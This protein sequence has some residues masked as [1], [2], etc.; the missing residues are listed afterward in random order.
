MSGRWWWWWCQD[1]D[2]DDDDDDDDEKAEEDDDND[3]EDDFAFAFDPVRR[4]TARLHHRSSNVKKTNVATIYKRY[5][6][7]WRSLKQRKQRRCPRG[8]K[9]RCFRAISNQSPIY[10]SGQ[11][12]VFEFAI[13]KN[14]C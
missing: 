9:D 11:N 14:D 12:F 2:G 5:M 10:A 6:K 1:D 13:R 8:I 4:A 7:K 3:D